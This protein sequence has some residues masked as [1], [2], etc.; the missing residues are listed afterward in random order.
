MNQESIKTAEHETS[1]G[2]SAINEAAASYFTDKAKNFESRI[3]AL[4][5]RVVPEESYFKSGKRLNN[6]SLFIFILI[7][8]IQLGLLTTLF[9]LFAND[10]NFVEW[11]K[12]VIGL[13]GIAA[14]AEIIYVPIKINLV[15]KR[16]DSL[17]KKS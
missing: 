16:I 3:S 17:E 7:P 13:I 4:E 14:I 2:S 6:V 9:I 11:A 8:I 12:W 1:T 15:E 10:S 5:K